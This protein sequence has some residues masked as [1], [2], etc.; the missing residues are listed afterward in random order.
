MRVKLLRSYFPLGVNGQIF[1]NGQFICHTIELPW[2]NNKR[3]I[4][5][6]PEGVYSLRK[7][8]NENL[9]C[10]V[11][12]CNV[13]NRSNIK[14]VAAKNALKELD[15]SIA[16]VS[17]IIGEG[18]GLYSKRCLY[19]LSDILFASIKAGKKTEIQIANSGSAILS[20]PQF[21]NQPWNG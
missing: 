14:I 1:I 21:L 7:N 6:I 13:P 15:G 4:S 12:V 2:K 3:N 19:K 8:Y 9:G 17:K 18:I 20:T 10:F 5:C 11:E 16:P